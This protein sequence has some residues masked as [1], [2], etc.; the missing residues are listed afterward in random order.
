MVISLLVAKRPEETINSALIIRWYVTAWSYR[1]CTWTFVRARIYF[2]YSPSFEGRRSDATR[3]GRA[4]HH[5]YS[6][7]AA[8]GARNLL[9]KCLQ[10]NPYHVHRKLP[11]QINIYLWDDSYDPSAIL[12]LSQAIEALGRYACSWRRK[13]T[14][15][16]YMPRLGNV[17]RVLGAAWS[18]NL[19]TW[20]IVMATRQACA[21]WARVRGRVCV[22]KLLQGGASSTPIENTSGSK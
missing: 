21:H 11:G 20:G 13:L 22:E 3:S 12:L 4:D 16:N 5:W 15:K 10:K 1:L 18:I 8:T 17:G 6:S 9:L 7:L 2:N 14:N 19:Y